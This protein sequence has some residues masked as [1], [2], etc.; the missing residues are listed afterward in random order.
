MVDMP[1][2]S[3]T[4]PNIHI[5]RLAAIMCKFLKENQ[6]F[7]IED[8]RDTVIN[9]YRISKRIV[10]KHSGNIIKGFCN[11]GVIQK[12]ERFKLSNPKV[13]NPK[14]LAVWKTK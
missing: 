8:F 5:W 12:T 6:E 3:S 13:G 4:S 7:T 11:V 1:K 10:A 9:D 2:Q 14:P